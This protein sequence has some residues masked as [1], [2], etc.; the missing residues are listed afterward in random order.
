MESIGERSQSWL[1]FEGPRQNGRR[2]WPEVELSLD[3]V[4][5]LSTGEA[6]FHVSIQYLPTNRR[7]HILPLEDYEINGH[8]TRDTHTRCRTHTQRILTEVS[9]SSLGVVCFLRFHCKRMLAA[10]FHSILLLGESCGQLR[11][12]FGTVF[13]T[14]YCSWLFYFWK[15][16]C[17][18]EVITL[19]QVC[20]CLVDC[21][22]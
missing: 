20:S 7:I 3:F 19:L 8:P 10:S 12:L 18:D 11:I 2:L 15:R 21:V 1:R 14:R 13:S 17:F 22:Q 5:P 9:R 6:P 16:S 4:F